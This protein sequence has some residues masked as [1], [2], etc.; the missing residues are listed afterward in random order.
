MQ[1]TYF[2]RGFH[3]PVPVREP[4]GSPAF[5]PRS[6]SG[7]DAAEACHVAT[8]PAIACG[9]GVGLWPDAAGR[10]ACLWLAGC[11]GPMLIIEPIPQAG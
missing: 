8:G 10:V 1:K 6:G 5:F 9:A 11:A 4:E 2:Y 3:A 7:T